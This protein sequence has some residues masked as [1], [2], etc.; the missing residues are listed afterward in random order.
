MNVDDRKRAQERLMDSVAEINHDHD[1]KPDV[2][3]ADNSIYLYLVV[4]PVESDRTLRT[5]TTTGRNFE[6]V[7]P[8]MLQALHAVSL[9]TQINP[10]FTLQYPNIERRGI[11]WR[12]GPTPATA[13]GR[14]YLDFEVRPDGA[15]RL[16][17]R[18]AGGRRLDPVGQPDPEVPLLL[19]E[20]TL[21]GLTRRAFAAMG[22]LYK[23][24]GFDG[25]VDTGVAVTGLAGHDI[26]SSSPTPRGQTIPIHFW[27]DYVET[28][29]INA[30][31][32]AEQESASALARLLLMPLIQATAQ[33]NDPFV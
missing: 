23:E 22:Y 5:W 27:Y 28:H 1:V 30:S 2:R 15:G 32:L 24:A 3:L 4:Q 25:V 29:T 26:Q 17:C 16:F 13:G 10:D 31:A 12:F 20:A 19:A 7:V 11:G 18:R 6:R 8:A 21:A 33:D 14:I 9:P